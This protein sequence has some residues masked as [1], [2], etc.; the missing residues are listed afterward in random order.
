MSNQS[1]IQAS[2][3]LVEASNAQPGPALVIQLSADSTELVV[4][5]LYPGNGATSLHGVLAGVKAHLETNFPAPRF[6]VLSPE[7]AGPYFVSFIPS[8][9]LIREKMLFALTKNT[10]LGQIGPKFAKTNVLEF[11]EL[12]EWDAAAFDRATAAIDKIHVMTAAERDLH[13]MALAEQVTLSQSSAAHLRLPQTGGAS[14]Q[15]TFQVLPDLAEK[16]H[17][18]WDGRLVS[19]AIDTASETVQLVQEASSLAAADL[20]AT[21]QASEPRYHLY[22]HK[23]KVAFVCLCPSGCAVKARIMYA[24]NKLG[25]ISYLH[26]GPLEGVELAPVVEVGDADE[27]E[28]VLVDEEQPKPASA[29]FSKPKGPRRR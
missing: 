27:L 22:G 12:G 3:E 5:S 15:L 24:A 20:P 28:G 6:V 14:T 2:A 26:T 9:A 25:L 19:M 1:G 4:D 17:G 8:E 23:G 10:L 21:V 18:P 13:H 7:G 29:G 11:S 16:L